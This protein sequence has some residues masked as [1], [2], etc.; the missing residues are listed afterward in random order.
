MKNSEM[1]E[2]IL[3]LRTLTEDPGCTQRD[4]AEKLNI[5]LGKTNLC[6][7]RLTEQGFLE[8][9]DSENGRGRNV[10][11]SVTAQGTACLEDHRVDAALILASGFGSR[12]VPLTYE[13]PKGLLE[14]YGERM[15][16][17]QIRQL[18]EVGVR[19][20]AVMVG[21]LKE[22][23]DYL[24]D[25]Y[26][27][28]LIYNP[29]FAEKNTLAT[30]YHAR[31]FLKGKNCYILSSDNWLKENLYHT[32]EPYAWYA[33]SFMQGETREW[34]IQAGKN[35]VIKS[36]SIG[37]QDAWC[38]YG[39]VYFS[40][41]FSEAFLPLIE[42]YYGRPGTDGFYWEDVL[43]RS[44]KELPDMYI[45]PQKDGIIFEF[46]N[47]EELRAF[48]ETYVHRS[49]SKAMALVSEIMGIPESMIVDIRCLKAGMT[50][51]SWRFCVSADAD[52]E[53]AGGSFICRIPGPGTEKL[54]NRAQEGA[55]Y[56][57]VA[58]LGITEELVYFDAGN[59]YKISKYYTEAHN[60]DFGDPEERR[61]CMTLLKK[62]HNSGSKLGHRFDLKQEILRYE[63][64]IREI[65]TEI[66]FADYAQ[67]RAQALDVLGYVAE[68]GRPEVIAHI[69]SVCDNFLFTQDG[70]KMIDWE[71]AGMADPLLDIAMAAIYSYMD[72][73]EA[74]ELLAEYREAPL[75]ENGDRQEGIAFDGISQEDAEMLVTAYMGL[76]GL[77]WTL[78][79]IY[80]MGLGEQFGDYTLKMYRYFKNSYQILRKSGKV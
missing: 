56:D 44:L 55:V 46:E 16:E 8:R 29:E 69:D 30:M 17:R 4:I 24:I 26:Q 18:Q 71:Y 14:V 64:L 10:V 52:V 3:I 42:Q 15:L 72:Y 27:V 79:G 73:D 12:F 5:S 67:V 54:I 48:D 41:D 43:I 51:K 11:F 66:P 39:P 60:A 49:G 31:H 25:K 80:K 65:G 34:A 61:A 20:I 50:N 23:F 77:L 70:L 59:G 78:W 9:N 2:D 76:G 32:F 40:R 57:T 6:M 62:L 75:E 7:Q 22:K 1:K 63:E 38:M 21:Y 28:R 33:A 19:D 58:A 68:A 36:V 45:N 13:T 47:L 74:L 53:Y 35:G 37:G